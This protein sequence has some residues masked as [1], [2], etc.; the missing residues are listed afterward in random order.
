MKNIV[1]TT[2]TNR[3]LQPAESALQARNLNLSS[4][5]GV[6]KEWVSRLATAQNVFELSNVYCGR[7][8]V[9]AVNAANAI[10]APLYVISAG[11]GLIAPGQKIPAY[12]LTTAKTSADRVQSKVDSSAS[13]SDWWEALNMS[14]GKGAPIAN[15]VKLNSSAVV[16]IGLSS[17]YLEMIAND[18]LSM[19]SNDLSRLRIIGPRPSQNV[20]E[21]IA[22]IVMPYDDRLDGPDSPIPGTRGDFA[23]RA[24]HHFCNLI[25]SSEKKLG[26]LGAD[27]DFVLSSLEGKRHPVHITRRSVSDAELI[28]LVLDL[29]GRANGRSSK[30]LRILRDEE[31]IACEQGRFSILFK[32]AKELHGL[33]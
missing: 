25:S 6:A 20:P 29:W 24:L 3:K 30:M 31:C 2:C 21:Q 7:S 32:Q 13:S 23:Q 17:S 1:V 5:T 19:G 18:I 22:P 8:Y 26:G 11:L 16:I 27:R 14:L 15:L 4:V 28:D 12:D 33:A 10:S 9:E